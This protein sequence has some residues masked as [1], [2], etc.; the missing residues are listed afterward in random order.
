M[1]KNSSLV[2]TIAGT[3][4][5]EAAVYEKP[6]IV[7]S[8]MGYNL[9]P[10]VFLVTDLNTLPSL[11][12]KALNT[13]VNAIDV[14]KYFT[15]FEQE[16]IHFPYYEFEAKLFKTFF[17]SGNFIDTEIDEKT[18][19]NYLVE[20]KNDYEIMAKKHIERIQFYNTHHFNR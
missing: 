12:R 9:L 8:D 16:S 14:D 7:F 19:Q 17:H 20:N 11:I 15:L 13:K 3:S 10:S 2:V 1:L 5:V 4:G 18:M 6:T